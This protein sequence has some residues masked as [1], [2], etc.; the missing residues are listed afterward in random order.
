ML[1]CSEP[2]FW[3]L[4]GLEIG[5]IMYML[6]IS[7]PAALCRQCHAPLSGAAGLTYAVSAYTTILTANFVLSSASQRL[8]R[9]S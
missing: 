6:L 2:Y 7:L 4:A 8:L 3:V 5:V 9:Q 1:L